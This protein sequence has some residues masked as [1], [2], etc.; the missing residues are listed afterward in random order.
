MK[1]V[2]IIFIVLILLIITIILF[3]LSHLNKKIFSCGKMNYNTVTS[4]DDSL[5]ETSK[6]LLNFVTSAYNDVC[7]YPL[8]KPNKDPVNIYHLT[9]TVST[10]WFKTTNNAGLVYIFDDSIIVSFRGTEFRADEIIDAEFDSYTYPGTTV[11][12]HTGFHK[13]FISLKDQLFD[14][15]SKNSGKKV[16]ITGHSLG[17]SISLIAGYELLNKFPGIDLNIYVFGCPKTGNL[18][19]VQSFKKANVVSIVN[20]F[21]IVPESPEKIN[22]KLYSVMPIYIFGIEQNSDIT[23]HSIAIYNQGIDVMQPLDATQ[24]TTDTPV[25]SGGAI[26]PKNIL[27]AL[28]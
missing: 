7:S 16:F 10:L 3:K 15:I 28:F 26:P 4:S 24:G 14:I 6:Y 2:I 8:F 22:N 19:F 27:R 20:Y 9:A 18:D 23:N 11:S 21:D 1:T 5:K 13:Y 25:T 17:A 12:V